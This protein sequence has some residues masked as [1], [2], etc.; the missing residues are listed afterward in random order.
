MVVSRP[1]PDAGFFFVL[2][3]RSLNL[4]GRCRAADQILVSLTLVSLRPESGIPDRLASDE[5]VSPCVGSQVFPPLQGGM[6]D[7]AG[8]QSD[9]L[10]ETDTLEVTVASAECADRGG[11]KYSLRGDDLTSFSSQLTS[12]SAFFGSGETFQLLPT[13]SF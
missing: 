3:K 6:D 13:S 12:R 1:G 5:C 11:L 8:F 7:S 9:A 10:D 4:G 2:R